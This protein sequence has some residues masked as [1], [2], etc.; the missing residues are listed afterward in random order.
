MQVKLTSTD[1]SMDNAMIDIEDAS[2]IEDFI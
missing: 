1:I 2:V